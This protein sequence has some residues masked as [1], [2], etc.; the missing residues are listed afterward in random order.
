MKTK[1]PN[2]ERQREEFREIIR[3]E[4]KRQDKLREIRWRE[5]EEGHEQE[6]SEDLF[7]KRRVER[8]DSSG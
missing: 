8:V 7:R 6:I 3:I 4:K 1:H 5:L 2:P